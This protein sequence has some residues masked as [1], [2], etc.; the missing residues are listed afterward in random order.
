MYSIFVIRVDTFNYVSIYSRMLLYLKGINLIMSEM[1]FL[2]SVSKPNVEDVWVYLVFEVFH[3][4]G[5][6][7]VDVCAHR[8]YFCFVL[9][10]RFGAG[11][12]VIIWSWIFICDNI[13]ICYLRSLG[14]QRVSLHTWGERRSCLPKGGGGGRGWY[15]GGGPNGLPLPPRVFLRLLDLDRRRWLRRER[16]RDRSRLDR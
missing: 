16:L 1:I 11:D 15:G 10:V 5:G 12:K 8:G 9:A 4:Y 7:F 14:E 3:E 13:V 2:P 6:I